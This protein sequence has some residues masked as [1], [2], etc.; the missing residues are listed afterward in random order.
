MKVSITIASYNQKERNEEGYFV[1]SINGFWLGL[2][3]WV[4]LTQGR[5][6]G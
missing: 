5:N 2:V 4:R 3:C 1:V 6:N